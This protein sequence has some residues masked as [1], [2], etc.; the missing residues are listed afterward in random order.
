MNKE[1]LVPLDMS[2][3]I[4]MIEMQMQE[5]KK[6]K[7]I[8]AK[9][10]DERDGYR[11]GQIQM[12]DICSNLQ[13]TIEKYVVERKRIRAALKNIREKCCN[14]E[15]YAPVNIEIGMIAIAAL[16]GGKELCNDIKGC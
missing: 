2:D 12:Q 14:A 4:A 9:L 6:L 10:T 15:D 7:D 1:T 16:E 3:A 13:D 8:E 5:I 11:N